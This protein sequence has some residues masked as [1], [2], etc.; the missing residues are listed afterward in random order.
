MEE[1]CRMAI[2]DESFAKH[3]ER[4][5][6]WVLRVRYLRKNLR[7]TGF[8]QAVRM[9]TQKA[10]LMD[11]RNSGRWGRIRFIPEEDWLF[12]GCLK[13]RKGKWRNWQGM[14]LIRLP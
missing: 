7:S 12:G 5:E 11:W 14:Q 3:Q 1:K 9:A 8:E 13:G 2:K 6:L 10:T 4:R